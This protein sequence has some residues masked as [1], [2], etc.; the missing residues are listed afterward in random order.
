MTVILS[1]L[2]YSVI[3]QSINVLFQATRPIKQ[4]DTHT[5]THTHREI[6]TEK[7]TQINYVVVIA[8]YHFNRSWLYFN[9]IV[10]MIRV[11]TRNENVCPIMV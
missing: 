11:L 8:L 10:T 6:K 2:L 7:H 3:N 5:H 4:E 9:I 1:M